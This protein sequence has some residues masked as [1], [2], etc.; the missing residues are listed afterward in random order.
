MVVSPAV[1]PVC[2]RFINLGKELGTTPGTAATATYTF[3]MT[4][5]G[6]VD[7]R[8]RLEDMAWRNSPAHLYNLIDGVRHGEIAMG[9]PIFADGIGYP[10]LG[11]LGDYYQYVNGG[12]V[13]TF[14]SLAGSTAVGA[15]M[16]AVA[17]TTG[18]SIG[19]IVS[20]GATATTAEEVRKITNVSAGSITLNA[21]L[22]QGH[23]TAGTIFA[24]TSITNIGH[25][26]TLL[27]PLAGYNGAGGGLSVQPPTYTWYD[28]SGVPA[29]TG[30]RQYTFG[31]VSELSIT[32]NAEQLVE[33]DAK[34]LAFASAI[35]AAQTVQTTAVAPQ[36]SWNTTVAIGGAGTYNDMEYKLALQRAGKPIWTNSG[37]QDPFA[38]PLG[39]CDASIAWK[40][41]PASDESEFLY[42]V[43]NTQP[44]CVVTSSN[45]LAG[46]SAAS[47]IIT[48][49]QMGFTE[50]VLEDSQEVFGFDLTTK[51][52]ANTVNVGP[53]L[54]Y[55][56][57]TITL[58][59]GQVNY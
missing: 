13:G 23:A 48:A 51:L 3:P 21:G 14:T 4:K 57:L 42:Y 31:R 35:S 7:N 17:G 59:N 20:I 22:Y 50:G 54:G 10:I 41:G 52:V 56:P 2:N 44:T 49:N 26:F 47:L 46:T 58:V 8:K 15:A 19:Q 36:P 45:G 25:V 27:N 30:A 11:A 9:G 37:Q 24:Y 29:G 12:V 28:Y 43:N 55:S 38:I 33:W 5:F 39:Y 40:F 18:L 53:S 16:I 34:M 6:P 1:W 32:G